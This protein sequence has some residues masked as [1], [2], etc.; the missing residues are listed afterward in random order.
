MKPY[1]EQ[2]EQT[3]TL[4]CGQSHARGVGNELVH[5]TW[6]PVVDAEGCIIYRQ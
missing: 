3:P 6:S 5:L 2:N 1:H 4:S